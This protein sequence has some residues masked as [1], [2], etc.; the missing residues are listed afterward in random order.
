MS[1]AQPGP[2]H[3]DVPV[4]PETRRSRRNRI[5][6]WAVVAAVLLVLVILA[7]S[8]VPRWWAETIGGLSDGGP[9][10]SGWW[11]FAIGFVSAALAVAVLART[12]RRWTGWKVPLALL[13]A[14][15]ILAAPNLFTLWI[16]VGTTRS[17]VAAERTLDV[18]APN[19]T[20]LTAWG[21]ALG[22]V[23]AVTGEVLWRSWRRRGKAIKVMRAGGQV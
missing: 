15:V 16:V 2:G 22:V 10:R 1:A 6:V 4:P 23:V 7:E 8:V 13:I 12:A 9:A 17:A 18:Q 3:D 14:G 11:G 5:I 19:F 21:A 20:A